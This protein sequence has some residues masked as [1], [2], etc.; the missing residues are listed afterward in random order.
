M[1]T[2]RVIATREQ[3]CWFVEVPDCACASLARSVGA[4]RFIAGRLVA[5]MTGRDLGDVRI[6]VEWVPRDSLNHAGPHQRAEF[7]DIRTRSRRIACHL[8]DRHRANTML[9][10]IPGRCNR[11]RPPRTAE[12]QKVAFQGWTSAHRAGA[13]VL[14]LPDPTT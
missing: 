1:R 6:V 3:E 2:Y 8:G 11:P 5:V 13:L 10:P 12:A 7:H 4:V 14:D 9:W